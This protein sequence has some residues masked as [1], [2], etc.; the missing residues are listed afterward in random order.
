[1]T[2]NILPDQVLLEIF[3]AR[4]RMHDG[5]IYG[6]VW[7]WLE[8][9]HVCQR[10]RRLIFGSPRGLDVQILCTHGT[11]VM[12][13]LDIWPPLPIAIHYHYDKSFTPYDANNLLAALD[14]PDRLRR[15]DLYLTRAQLAEVVTV[16]QQPLPAL[17][18]L[19]WRSVDDSTPPLSD[20][21]LGGSTPCLQYLHLDGI[22]YPALS[23]LL[24]SARGLVDLSLGNIPETGYIPPES[25]VACLATLPKLESFDIEYFSVIPH[26]N[27]P[28]PPPVTR[29]LLPALTSFDFQGHSEYL[30]ALVSWIDSPRLNRLGVDY[31][32]FFSRPDV[33]FPQLFKFI[34][35]SKDPEFS[36]IKHADVIFSGHSVDF[37]AYPCLES[38]RES[39]RVVLLIECQQV[40]TQVFH[41]SQVFSQPSTMLSRIVHL[42]LIQHAADEEDLHIGEWLHLLRR[43][44]TVRTLHV[45]RDFSECIALALENASGE[46]VV[47]VLP[48]VD[49]IFLEGLPASCITNFLKAR[50]LSDLPV[51]IID[52]Q[53]EF[54]ERVKSYFD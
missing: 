16:M 34:D 24:L 52:T 29:F 30:E 33:Q 54:N 5:P 25:L 39:T 12:E 32:N 26:T 4:R 15:V 3:D 11:P 2:I 42:K 40:E 10:W 28:R 8:L 37:E 7:G 43:F 6:S 27:R 38:S 41:I 48:L 13:S 50:Q 9:V 18:H 22:V 14:N 20:S 49:L 46:M 23:A 17:T 1:M 35:R 45:S 19:S 21:F 44:S 36:V 53:A 31:V 51:T 47:E